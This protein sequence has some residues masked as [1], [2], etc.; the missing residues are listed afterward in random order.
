MHIRP[1]KASKEIRMVAT[2]I[3]GFRL[4]IVLCSVLYFHFVEMMSQ[5]PSVWQDKSEQKTNVDDEI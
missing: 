1:K 2:M 4:Q 5:L 3:D